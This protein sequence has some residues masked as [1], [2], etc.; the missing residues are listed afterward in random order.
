[1]GVQGLEELPAFPA[2]RAGTADSGRA[3]SGKGHA[4]QMAMP[5]PGDSLLAAH[6]IAW[7]AKTSRQIAGK[8]SVY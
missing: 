2:G 5:D 8:A 6:G 1:M 7:I 3:G 4:Q